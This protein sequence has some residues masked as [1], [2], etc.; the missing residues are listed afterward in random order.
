M[1]I[2]FISRK[3]PPSIGGMQNY[4]YN[5]YKQFS[6]NHEVIDIILKKSQS[7]L[8][9]FFPWTIVYGTYLVLTKKIDVVYIGDGLLSPVALYFQKIFNK[10]VILTIYGLDVI[11]DKFFY[12]KMILFFLPKVKNIVSISQATQ[13]EAYKRGVEQKS[14]TV[15]PV[16]IDSKS[17]VSLD[18]IESRKKIERKFKSNFE[19]KIILFTIGRLV[20]R[21]GVFWFIDNVILELGDNYIYLVAGSGNDEDRIKSLIAEKKI[22]NNVILLGE[23]SDEDKQLLFSA[24]DIFLSPNISVK[25]DMEGFGIVNVEAGLYNLPVV[26]SNIEGL[27][28]AVIDGGTGFLVPEQNVS[29][30]LNAIKNI[31]KI[32][33]GNI[34]DVVRG[35][36]GW[37]VV[38]TRYMDVINK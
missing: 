23:V 2:L 38:H 11:Y 10:K 3:Y 25:N 22:E 31:Y 8:I 27:K 28:D 9:W 16:G 35:E 21:K 30:Y 7:N 18:Y 13:E 36:F 14:C 17:V 19:D 12:Q 29:M 20:K 6:M 4:A 24:S 33:R 1:K 32:H 15:I 26:A 37:D 5:L 34:C